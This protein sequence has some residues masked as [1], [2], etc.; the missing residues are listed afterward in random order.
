MLVG[1]AL[2]AMM[3]T[4]ARYRREIRAAREHIDSLGSQVVKT[5]CGAIEYARVGKGYPV[6]VVHGTMGGFDQGLMLA[7]EVIGPDFQ[8][9]SISRFGY[10]GSPLPADANINRQAD[11]YACLLDTLGIQQV[12]VFSF[13]A[14]ATSAIRFAAR[15]PE[16]LSALILHSPAAPGNVEVTSPPRVLFDTLLRSD[17]VYWAMVNYFRPFMQRMVGVPQGFELTPELEA[18]V[19][20]TLA[21]TLPLSER[22][23]GFVFDG[24][25]STP[26]W[27]EEISETSPYPL[28]EIE[29][30]VLA[31]NALDDPYAIPENVRGLATLFPNARLFVVPDGGHLILG[32]DAEVKAEIAHFLNSSIAGLNGS[33]P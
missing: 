29:I 14:G 19:K 5:N 13:S 8:I 22:I 2:V 11:A 32:H 24:Y 20:D 30:P 25:T 17:F 16:R 27:S 26:E 10:L 1:I 23:D 21:R 9:I 31:V 18:E 6:L 33:R 12:A 28:G 3:P 4:A 7:D 15:H